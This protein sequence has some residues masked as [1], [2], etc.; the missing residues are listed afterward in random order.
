MLKPAALLIILLTLAVSAWAEQSTDCERAKE[1]DT[2]ARAMESASERVAS[3]RE[4]T[5][6]CASFNYLYKLGR[7]QQEVGDAAGA[8]VSYEKA[9]ALVGDT[10]AEGLLYGRLAEVSLALDKADEAVAIADIALA[11]TQPDTP[12]WVHS[13]RKQADQ[14]FSEQPITADRITRSLVT[15]RAFAVRP[16]IHL[17]ILFDSGKDSLTRKGRAQVAELGKALSALP[18]NEVI[19]LVGHTDVGGFDF[20]TLRLSVMR[21]ERVMDEVAAAYPK[22]AARITA[23]GRGDK[24]PRYSQASDE[25]N[26]LNRR[27]EVAL[28]K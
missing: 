28:G 1:L 15:S 26:I 6:L 12:A 4:I 2:R 17:H 10:R 9:R 21:A 20:Y 8:K 7:A 23:S 14:R 18:D 16:R 3:Y 11:L 27:V 5:T 24:E 13:V 25:N 22:L 19:Q